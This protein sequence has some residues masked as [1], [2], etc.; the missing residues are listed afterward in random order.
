[1]SCYHPLAAYPV[2]SS[3]KEAHQKIG[4][5]FVRNPDGSKKVFSYTSRDYQIGGNY[6]DMSKWIHPGAIPVP[7]GHC[8]GCRLDY[9]RQWADRMMLELDHSKTAIFA[10]CTYDNDHVSYRFDDETGEL[11]GLSLDKRSHQLFMKR[12]RKAFPGREIRFYGA[13]EYGSNTHRPHM[14]Y[15]LFG[16][17]LSD[18]DDLRLRGL[19]ELKQPY[20]ISDHFA[21]DI[22]QNGLCVLTDVSWNTCA[23]VARYV[24]K[25]INHDYGYIEEQIGAE[26]EFSV[27]SRNPGLGRFYMD[28]HPDVFEYDQIHLFGV[29]RGIRVPRYLFDKLKETDLDLYLK[30]KEERQLNASDAMLLKLSKTELGFVDLLEVEENIA[31][32]RT[33]VLL[34]RKDV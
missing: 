32:S 10:T 18:F 26:P 24:Q 13:G 2:G 9:C 21:H 5:D 20:Y 25:K 31:L 28:D 22:W 16:L 14:H 3:E 33:S 19:N 15:I 4:R 30:M 34:Q 6:D 12:L 29:D 7:C 27:M 17:S 11:L 23:Y 1:M 8:L